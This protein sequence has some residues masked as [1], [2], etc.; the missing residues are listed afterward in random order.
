MSGFSRLMFWNLGLNVLQGPHH[1]ALNIIITLLFSSKNCWTS[2]S[3]RVIM[4]FSPFW[5]PDPILDLPRLDKL[6]MYITS[7][8]TNPAEIVVPALVSALS[9]SRHEARR[10]LDLPS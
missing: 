9:R 3:L 4:L 2:V 5:L 7:P 8:L 10:H 1:D 6:S